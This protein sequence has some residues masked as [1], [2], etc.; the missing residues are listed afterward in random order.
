MH[1]FPVQMPTAAR[2]GQAN[3]R[4]QKLH[5]GG[6]CGQQGPDPTAAVRSAQQQGTAAEA[7][8]PF[9][10]PGIP[11]RDALVPVDD[12]TAAT[13]AAPSDLFIYY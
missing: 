5:V 4:S 13:Q 12:F 3:A 11:A 8:Q 2:A 6:S 9:C 1:L 7:G 10:A